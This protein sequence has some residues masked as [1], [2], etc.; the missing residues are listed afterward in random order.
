MKKKLLSVLI[1][2][3]VT[4]YSNAQAPQF[5]VVRPDG[6]TYI[7]PTWDSAHSKAQDGDYIYMPGIYISGDKTITKS[8]NIFGAG[9]YPDSTVVTGK[10][11]ITG[12]ITITKKCMLEGFQCQ[13]VISNGINCS[14]SSFL[15]MNI[16][17]SLLL[18]DASNILIDGCVVPEIWGGGP[19]MCI[20]ASDVFIKNTILRKAGRLLYSNFQNCIF[21]GSTS[22]NTSFT[23]ANSTFSNCFFRGLYIQDLLPC[24]TLVGNS[25]N[26]SLW[27]SNIILSGQNN[28]ITLQPD[29]VL[30]NSGGNGSWFDYSYNYHLKPTTIYATSGNDGTQIGIYGGSSPYREGAVPQN[31]HI[32]YKQVASSTNS[33]GQLQIQFKVRT[34]N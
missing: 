10:T 13:N 31:P 26:N 22:S 20:S 25:S 11:V 28:Q 15:R 12:I 19:N 7:C 33:N 21:L 29:T 8:L 30:V 32:Y 17:G 18:N 1:I 4:V 2:F 5:A 9:H 34:G 14:G 23:V 24:F 16:S 27:T 3:S 6:T